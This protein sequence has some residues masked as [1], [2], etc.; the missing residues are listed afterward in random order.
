MRMMTTG[1]IAAAHCCIRHAL[2]RPPPAAFQLGESCFESNGFWP[3]LVQRY[4]A[5]AAATPTS[6]R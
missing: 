6:A 4:T 1:A 2:Q 5:I 3:V